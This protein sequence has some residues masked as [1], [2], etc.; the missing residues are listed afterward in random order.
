MFIAVVIMTIA[1]GL[2]LIY[3]YAGLVGVLTTVFVLGLISIIAA[4]TYGYYL[5]KDKEYGGHRR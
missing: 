5:E 3:L 2:G 1:S 4:I